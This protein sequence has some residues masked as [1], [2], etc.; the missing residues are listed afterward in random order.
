MALAAIF[1]PGPLGWGQRLTVPGGLSSSPRRCFASARQC[2]QSHRT[3][4]DPP[5]IRLQTSPL[6]PTPGTGHES[7]WNCHYVHDAFKNKPG[8]FWACAR[9]RPCGRRSPRW[10]L[11]YRYQRLYTLPE[12][13]RDFSCLR[14]CHLYST[15]D[16][17][18]WKMIMLYLA[19]VRRQIRADF[20]CNRAAHG[21][22]PFSCF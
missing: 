6:S 12:L 3:R 2:L 1:S 17:R 9:R 19:Y 4:Q 21:A 16:H 22:V 5:S 13:I 8:R 7:H 11:T 10:P 15:R 14:C 20:E 18:A